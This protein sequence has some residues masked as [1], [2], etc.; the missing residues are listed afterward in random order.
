M[1]LQKVPLRF[2][3]DRKDYAPGYHKIIQDAHK[4]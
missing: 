1:D 2:F 4:T 3:K